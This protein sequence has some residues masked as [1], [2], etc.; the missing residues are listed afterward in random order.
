MVAW[1]DLWQQSEGG[2]I[3]GGVGGLGG[4]TGQDEW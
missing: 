1:P 2:R 3:D 4:E